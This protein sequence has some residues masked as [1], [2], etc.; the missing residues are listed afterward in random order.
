MQLCWLDNLEMLISFYFPVPIESTLS[1]EHDILCQ[2]NSMEVLTL[3]QNLKMIVGDTK[4]EVKYK[5]MQ[6]ILSWSGSISGMRPGS[7]AIP[8]YVS[9]DTAWLAECFQQV[10][11]SLSELRIK[12]RFH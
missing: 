4:S 3:K 9:T 1:F 7:E 11:T 5:T 10:F 6:R 8:S 2:I 12:P